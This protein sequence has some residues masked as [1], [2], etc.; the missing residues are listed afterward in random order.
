VASGGSGVTSGSG[1]AACT[2]S[3]TGNIADLATLPVGGTATYTA[4][5]SLSNATIASTLSNTATVATPGPVIDPAPANNS[6]TDVDTV[7]HLPALLTAGKTLSGSF[8]EGGTVTYSIELINHGAGAQRDNP[9]NEFVD[10][11]PAGLAL[12]SASATSGTAV[13]TL[14]INT[15]TWDGS[16]SPGGAVTITIVAT[17]SATEGSTISNQ[18]TFSYDSLGS[19]VN[20]ATGTTDAFV[21]ED[22]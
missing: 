18:G 4:I 21:C 14:G 22:L 6:G 1:G 15:V 19:G 20:D 10:V 11:L 9:G 17:I 5:C 16:I 3:G 12:V 7:I 13:A 8:I 2:A